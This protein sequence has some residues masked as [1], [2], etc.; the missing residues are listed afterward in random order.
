MQKGKLL[1]SILTGVAS[2]LLLGTLF[3]PYKKKESFKNLFDKEEDLS[4]YSREDLLNI[5]KE[6]QRN[7]KY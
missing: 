6:L 5:L 4:K 1:L 3:A 2:G 7:K